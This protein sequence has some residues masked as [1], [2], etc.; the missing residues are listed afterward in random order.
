M[1]HPIII[2]GSGGHA[3]VVADILYQNGENLIGFLDDFKPLGELVMGYP[4]LGPLADVSRYGDDT[5][6]II[7]IGDNSLR[8]ALARE[9]SVRWHTAVHPTAVIARDASVAEGTVIMAHAVVGPSARVGRHC[10]IN[11]AAD[12][13]HDN[14][15]G[16]FVHLSPHAALGGTVSVGDGTHI[17][18][19]AVVRNGIR[20]TSDCLIGAGAV[21]VKDILSQGTY[22][23]VPAE[24]VAQ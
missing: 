6:F 15:I 21:V 23:G 13:E 5:A 2:L 14:V 7:G 9:R 19:G 4:V 20:I 18:I 11:T 12:V 3:K 24:R 1:A 22:V 8:R 17:G 16:D 10:I